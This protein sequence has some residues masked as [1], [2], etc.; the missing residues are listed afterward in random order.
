MSMDDAVSLAITAINLK[1][2]EK[3]VNNIRMSKIKSN[4]KQFEKVS[5]EE[6]TKHAHSHD[7]S[8]K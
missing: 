7:R 4:T 5:T 1:N 8:S 2:D 6:L 3:N